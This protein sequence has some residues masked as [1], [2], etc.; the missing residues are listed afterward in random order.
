MGEAIG[1]QGGVHKQ[2][3]FNNCSPKERD[4]LEELERDV[5][6]RDHWNLKKVDKSLFSKKIQF[7]V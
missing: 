1:T 4:H 3:G 7:S 5:R 6:I 2:Y